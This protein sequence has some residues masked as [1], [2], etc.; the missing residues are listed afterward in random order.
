M[1]PA[2]PADR[3]ETDTRQTLQIAGLVVAA[4]AIT[5]VA[6]YFLSNLYF[7]DRSAMYGVAT[8]DHITGVRLTFG[9]FTGIVG[10]AT[11][12]ATVAPRW[13]GH[14][15]AAITGVAAIVAGIGAASVGMTAVLPASLLVAGLVFPVLVWKSLQRV[16]GAWAFLIGMCAVFATVLLFGATKVRGALG[17]G[18][19][20][21]LIIP[22]V[23]TV[24]TVALAMLRDDYRDA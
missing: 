5:N 14:G 15:I 17:V 22:G 2:M 24:G 1:L 18:L 10:L 19:W 20:T 7:Q 9:V 3:A 8:T 21:A 23:L 13:V 12:A 16:R 6:F 11:V 4:C